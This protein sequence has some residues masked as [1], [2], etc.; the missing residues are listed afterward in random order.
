MV[1]H[2][3]KFDDEMEAML[4]R[5]C[6]MT[7][8]R[9]S[10]VMKQA[11]LTLRDESAGR[12]PDAI[13]TN[14][15]ARRTFGLDEETEAALEQ[16]RDGTGMRVSEA[17]KKGLEAL[18]EKVEKKKRRTTWEALRDF[19]FGPGDPSL[20]PARD[21]RRVVREAILRKHHR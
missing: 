4:Q 2:R 9:E 21:S 13:Q 18:Q 17:F 14:D 3:V 10:E 1:K 5:L 16:V 20:P 11:I 12:P 19:D 7:G 8:L 15:T 6:A